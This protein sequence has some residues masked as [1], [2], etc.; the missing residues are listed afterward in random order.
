[1]AK[2]YLDTPADIL[3]YL[4]RINFDAIDKSQ[5]EQKLREL[6]A[7]TSK[8]VPKRKNHNVAKSEI[9]IPNEAAEFINSLQNLSF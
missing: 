9:D 4:R 7:I 5:A 1:M 3:S 6:Y 8:H 2:V